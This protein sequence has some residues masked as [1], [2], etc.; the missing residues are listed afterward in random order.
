MMLMLDSEMC[1]V[2]YNKVSRRRA[3]DHTAWI[4][5]IVDPIRCNPRYP[6]QGSWN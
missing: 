6:T 3:V 2:Q 1:R 4:M 5:F